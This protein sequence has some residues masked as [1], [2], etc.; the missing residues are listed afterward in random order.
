MFKVLSGCNIRALD[1][2]NLHHEYPRIRDTQLQV[3]GSWL[4]V[5]LGDEISV[6]G[7]Q[8]QG[9]CTQYVSSF[10]M[11]L[12]LSDTTTP[13]ELQEKKEEK[14]AQK[15]PGIKKEQD[16]RKRFQIDKPAPNSA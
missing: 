13:Y 5:D 12:K 10:T 14:Q 16:I 7:L 1:Y 3:K 11:Q 8:L 6:C 15:Q 9:L 4:E 2:L